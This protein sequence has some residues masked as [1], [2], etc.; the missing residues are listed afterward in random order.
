MIDLGQTIRERR[1]VMD[2]SLE[3]L[4]RELGDTPGQTFLSR[5]ERG[6]V[7]VSPA[8]AA[9]IARALRLPEDDVLLAAG[10][11]PEP[12]MQRAL[13]RLREHIGTPAPRSVLLPV[14]DTTGRQS[15]ERRRMMAQVE[16]A[17]LVDFTGIPNEPYVGECLV[18][19]TRKPVNNQGVVVTIDGTLSAWTFCKVDKRTWIENGRGERRAA[20]YELLGVI[21]RV[22][23]ERVLVD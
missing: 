3:A 1:H 11:A 8:L 10:F 5:V 19:T 23:T 21:G 7:R 14:L 20:G 2:M 9:R 6:V 18:L 15:G 4:A 16:D 17:F 13:G 12:D 22:S